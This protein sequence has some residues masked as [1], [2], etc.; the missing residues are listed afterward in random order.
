MGLVKMSKSNIEALCDYLHKNR[1][2]LYP[3]ENEL[4]NSETDFIVNGYMK[5][6]AVILQQP[7]EIHEGQIAIYKRLLA[8]VNT[9]KSVE[10]YL[11][12]A[13]E[14]TV[15]E[16]L[17]FSAEMKDLSAK[18]RFVLDALVLISINQKNDEQVRLVAEFVEALT[19]T[20]DELRYI[21]TM[22]RAI[23]CMD[24]SKYVDACELE[25][26][27]IPQEVF[28]GY[29]KLLAKKCVLQNDR[30]TIFQPSC[31]EDVTV[32]KLKKMEDIKTP[33]IKLSNV[34]LNVTEYPLVI[35]NRK[36][37]VI[38]NCS[39]VGGEK[40]PIT[41]LQCEEVEIRNCEFRDFTSYTIQI[42]FVKEVM[43]RSTDFSNCYY[44]YNN[45]S[46]DWSALGGLIHVGECYDLETYEYNLKPINIDSCHF[47]NCGGRNKAN[48]Y[49]KAFLINAQSDVNDSVFTNCWHYNQNN[50]DPE[51]SNRTMFGADSK[52]TNCRFDNSASFC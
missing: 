30:M 32:E 51:N 38:E 44:T 37:V 26:D 35:S 2:E 31:E 39:F 7:N 6:L 27:G 45:G 28:Y 5:M 49:R 8:S 19:V 12:M 17:N 22:A 33:I 14:I 29:M 15:E 23:V 21:S 36:K 16:F 34:K 24:M 3:I 40:Y 9:D 10:D 48:Y 47:T 25:F 46:N 11:R 18:Y 13:L 1:A 42:D 41:F 52:A 4:L 50:I 43:I 20:K